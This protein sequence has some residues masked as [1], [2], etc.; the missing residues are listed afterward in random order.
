MITGGEVCDHMGW[1]VRSQRVG[2]VLKGVGESDQ[3]GGV[4]DYKGWM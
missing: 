3:Y 2:C 4:S 1:G